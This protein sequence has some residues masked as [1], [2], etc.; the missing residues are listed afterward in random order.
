ML[1]NLPLEGG[2]KFSLY[3]KRKFL[4]KWLSPTCTSFS[5]KRKRI[6]PQKSVTRSTKHSLIYLEY[7]LL[8]KFILHFWLYILFL[9]FKFLFYFSNF[10]WLM[11]HIWLCSGF[12]SGS[13]LRGSLLAGLTWP[14]GVLKIKP[15]S[16]ATNGSTLNLLQ[17]LWFRF[18]SEKISLSCI[19][20]F[21]VCVRECTYN[22][23]EFSFR[24]LTTNGG[25]A[26]RE[27]KWRM[28]GGWLAKNPRSKDMYV[29]IQPS[30]R[31]KDWKKKT[32][33]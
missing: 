10:L 27:L 6:F 1:N 24:R 8:F 33:W 30:N 7:S 2:W 28:K 16:T 32:Q 31:I 14:H 20:L 18:L 22:S 25:L 11:S 19:F 3:D 9:C 4:N 29:L 21:G 15:R 5:T 13:V 23:F 17:P 26:S 12:I